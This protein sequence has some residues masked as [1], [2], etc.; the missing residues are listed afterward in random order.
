MTVVMIFVFATSFWRYVVL[1]GRQAIT[2]K[3]EIRRT[4]EKEFQIVTIKEKGN[5]KNYIVPGLIFRWAWM[6]QS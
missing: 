1:K 4:Y 2:L 5:R 6:L 3:S